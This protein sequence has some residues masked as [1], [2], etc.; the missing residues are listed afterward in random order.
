MLEGHFL[1]FLAGSATRLFML[2]Q[3]VT[4]SLRVGGA[5]PDA[6]LGHGSET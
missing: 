5:L 1:G 2:P 6:A 3:V 4:L